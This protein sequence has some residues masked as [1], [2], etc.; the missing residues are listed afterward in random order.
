MT[1]NI[2]NLQPLNADC[3]RL[4]PDCLPT[5]LL[6][7]CSG[8]EAGSYLRLTD[9]P[10]V[11][12]CLPA[13]LLGGVPAEREELLHRNVKRFRGGLVS[14]AHR[15][16]GSLN[17]RLESNKEEEDSS[18]RCRARREHLTRF[19]ISLLGTWLRPRPKSGLDCLV[20]AEFARQRNSSNI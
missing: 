3:L 17:S 11:S 1:Y 14:E 4:S 6:P 8:S 12:D 10:T 5:F 13:L 2:L 9:L 20:R 18:C 7:M 15:L 16:C 19:K